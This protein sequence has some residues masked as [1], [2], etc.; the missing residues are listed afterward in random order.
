M[1]RL[2]VHT[3]A[4]A[5]LAAVPAAA[6]APP[7]FIVD[8]RGW[9]HGIGLAQ[10]GAYGY[11]RD[12]G[13]S[14]AWILEHYYPGTTLGPTSVSTVRVLLADDRRSLTVGSDAPFS[15]TDAD[16]RRFQLPEGSVQ[17]DASLRIQAEG[18]LRTLASPLEFSRGTAHLELGGRPYRG[19]LVVRASGGTLAAI[20]HVGLEEYLYG[21]VPDEMP[22]SWATE[23]L[24]AQAVAARS[25]AVVSRRTSG[26]FDL[27]SDTR[28]QVYGGVRSE[29][30]RT[31]AA[32]DATAGQVVLYQGRVAHTFF[33]STSGGRTAA[34]QDVWNASPVP[35]LVSVPDPHDG[36]SPYHR[37]G[38]FRFTSSELARRLGS[39]AP[40]GS[41]LDLVVERNAS[42]RVERVT[43]RGSRDATTFSGTTFQSRL[44][45]RS[46]WFSIGVLSL[47]GST[48]VTYG[49]RASL[50]GIARVTGP[51]WLEQRTWDGRWERVGPAERTAAG[52]FRTIARPRITT[53]YRVVSRSGAG[54][55]H[56]VSIAPRVRLTEI[57]RGRTLVGSVRPAR[58]GA[59][60]SVQRLADGRWTTVAQA[61]TE[62]SGRFRVQVALEPGTYRA[63]ARLGAGYV[64]GAS[65]IFD[66]VARSS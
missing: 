54:L 58:A 22:P 28:S 26:A 33:H 64:P 66:V 18:Q 12:E 46:S 43:A 8:G 1:R 59:Q 48:R 9:G 24:K 40:D 4:F 42:Q 50:R 32:I 60:V 10:Y 63:V 3:F 38:P 16:G 53:W 7:V 57:R 34:I 15:V 20:N 23:A 52:A 31:N 30:T 61:R 21:V 11:A 41:L 45:L 62:P 27:F 56:R 44:D 36:L 25:Y 17:L 19:K 35:Y 6:A 37:W 5:A 47:S 39:L 49:S 14:H 2:L 29:E 55:A 51:A 65:A 13:R